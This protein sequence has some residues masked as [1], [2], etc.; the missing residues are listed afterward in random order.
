M[1]LLIYHWILSICIY[2]TIKEIYQS[3]N[4]QRS[5]TNIDRD[6]L[7]L[8][9]VTTMISTIVAAGNIAQY[10][11]RLIVSASDTVLLHVHCAQSDISV[12]L[13]S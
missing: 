2:I 10:Y 13:F 5:E 3:R 9:A 8:I 1:V 4:K 6:S 7:S 11:I 12:R